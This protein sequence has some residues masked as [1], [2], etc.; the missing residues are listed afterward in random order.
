M[1]VFRLTKAAENDLK[2]IARYT[3]ERWGR[4]QRNKYLRELDKA[5]HQ[6]ADHPGLGIRRDAI[7]EGHYSFLKNRHLIFY[8]IRKERMEIVRVL[9]QRMDIEDHL[10]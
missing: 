2:D 4:R 9:H 7:L 6:I 5:F 8:R 3:Q 1:P 10:R